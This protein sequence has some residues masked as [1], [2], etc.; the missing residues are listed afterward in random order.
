MSDATGQ[1]GFPKHLSLAGG[2]ILTGLLVCLVAPGAAQTPAKADPDKTKAAPVPTDKVPAPVAPTFPKLTIVAKSPEVPDQ[3]KLINDMLAEGW[4]ANKIIP[5]GYV[6]DHE[7]IRRASLDIIGRIAKPEEIEHF[8]KDPKESRRSMLIDR[9]LDSD[10]YA[11]HWS[12]TWSNWLLSRTGVFG[13]G[14]Y[15]D[16]MTAWLKDQFALNVSYDKLVTSLITASGENAGDKP[17]GAVNFILA[18]VGEPIPGAKAAEE[19]QF[20]M[21]PITSRITRIFLGTQVQCAQCH[22]HP[23][24][25]TLKQE[26]FWGVN[27]F[28]RQVKRVGTPPQERMRGMAYPKLEL[29]DDA[30][31]DRLATVFYEKRNGVLKEVSAEFLPYG[32]KKHGDKL[33]AKI[34]GVGRRAELAKYILEHDNFARAYANRMWGVFFGKGF[35]NPIDDFNDQNQPSNP[36]LLNGLAGAFKNYGYDQKK[37]IRWICN[38]HAYNLSCVAN[39]TNDK[40]EQEVFFSR[41]LMKAMSP[42]QLFE[43]LSVATKAE[44]GKSP[45]ERKTSRERWLNNLVAN[46]GD[47]EGNEVNFNGTIVQALLMMNGEDI[48]GALKAKGGTVEIA[49]TKKSEALIIRDLFLA[50]LNREPKPSELVTLDKQFRLLKPEKDV[51]ARYYDLFWALLNSNEFLLNH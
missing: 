7:F 10:E 35:V 2:L 46:F 25:N 31:V 20:E 9:L 21:V 16:E 44:A 18:H 40:P 1:R 24:Q 33:D 37:M 17:N 38:S 29:K 26:H 15:H 47:D 39:K 43:S 41:M 4:K 30:S 23:F 36:E 12:N 51:N 3:V 48:N 13:H 34:T 5:A 49:L 11:L 50:T 19:G 28:L 42:E 27:A 45:E 6:D 14:T 8:L 22:D 32:E